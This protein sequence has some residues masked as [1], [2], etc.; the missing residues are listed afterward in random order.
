MEKGK[1]RPYGRMPPNKRRLN[2]EATKAVISET[3]QQSPTQARIVS[4]R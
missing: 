3:V 1:Y 4:G 2:N